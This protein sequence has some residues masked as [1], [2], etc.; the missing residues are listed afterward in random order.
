MG[1]TRQR[2]DQSQIGLQSWEFKLSADD[3]SGRAIFPWRPIYH[4]SMQ[5]QRRIA[6]TGKVTENLITTRA[7]LRP[8][9]F[10]P[11]G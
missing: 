9:P 2:S 7:K 11:N 3:I 5:V 8:V 4:A 10:Q 6:L 1:G